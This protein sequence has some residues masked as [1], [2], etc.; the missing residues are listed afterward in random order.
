MTGPWQATLS[1]LLVV[2]AL[3]AVAWVLKR[4][5]QPRMPGG[6]LL[7]V[8]SA[9]S[10][11]PRERVVVVE[12]GETWLVLGVAPGRVSAISSM[13]RGTTTAAPAPIAPQPAFA[14][15]LQKL[16]VPGHGR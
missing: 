5:V 4:V 15:W 1:M 7:R 2:A 9:V 6:A 14:E 11:G 13:P 3:L 8:L 16:G 12:A 10:V